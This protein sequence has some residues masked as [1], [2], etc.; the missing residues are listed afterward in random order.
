VRS[1]RVSA[2]ERLGE[3]H[4]PKT[5]T[6]P[7]RQRIP[8]STAVSIKCTFQR[9]HP[10]LLS[11]ALPGLASH[12]IC[13]S[14][15]ERKPNALA[16]TICF[17]GTM[18]DSDNLNSIDDDTND[19]LPPAG[20]ASAKMD[21]SRPDWYIP[22]WAPRSSNVVCALLVFSSCITSTAGLHVRIFNESC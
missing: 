11:L 12:I 17:I 2:P 9:G 22:N 20:Q 15:H 8:A 6:L 14:A 7:S 5:E 16:R 3:T 19:L 4:L 1:T 13:L 21:F 18:C 10:K